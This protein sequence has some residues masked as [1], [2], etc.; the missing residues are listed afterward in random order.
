MDPIEKK[1]YEEG[2]RRNKITAPISMEKTLSMAIEQTAP[3]KKREQNLS[4][5]LA[6][7]VVAVLLFSLTTYNYPALAYYSKKIIGFDGVPDLTLSV[8][9]EQEKGQ[10]IDKSIILSDGTTFT[11]DGIMT[12]ENQFILFYT[13]TNPNGVK[14]TFPLM[15]VSGFLTK[16]R[17]SHGTGASNDSDT[18]F[19]GIAHFTPINLFAKNLTLTIA[20][21]G[22]ESNKISFKHDPNKAMATNFKQK[23][24]QSFTVDQG[25]L[26]FS[27]ITAT[28]TT[29]IIS[30]TSTVKNIDKLDSNFNL[31]KLIANGDEVIQ[32]GFG[33]ETGILGTEFEI[34]YN[35]LRED[36]ETLS[37]MIQDFVGYDEIDKTILLEHLHEQ[38]INLIGQKEL[39]VSEV[40]QT[41]DTIEIKIATEKNILLDGVSI[42]TESGGVTLKTTVDEAYIEYDNR[43]MMKERTLVFETDKLPHSLNIK[44]LHHLKPYFQSIDILIE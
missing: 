9:N 31:V 1:L 39:F 23:I 8:L 33:Y 21:E 30:G 37:L 24:N 11:V 34:E 36:T 2:K 44:G 12:D 26:K 15:H 20:Y 3:Y 22:I 25:Q 32:T 6:I 29:T 13:L 27:S 35:A 18:E 43:E 16:S 4:M 38:P 42:E 10:V 17:Q 41:K 5:K 19:K 40:H 28:P 14:D 7:T